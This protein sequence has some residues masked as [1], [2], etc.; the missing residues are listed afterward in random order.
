MIFFIA[1]QRSSNVK[2]QTDN[3]VRMDLLSIM[4]YS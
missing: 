1:M 3:Y 2:E 4:P